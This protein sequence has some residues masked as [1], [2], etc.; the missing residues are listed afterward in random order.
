MGTHINQY[1][2][3]HGVKLEMNTNYMLDAYTL[4]NSSNHKNIVLVMDTI[5]ARNVK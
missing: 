4:K 1:L 3:Q 5:N 2:G